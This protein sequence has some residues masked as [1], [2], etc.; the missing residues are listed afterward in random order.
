MLR[1]GFEPGAK[2]ESTELWRPPAKGR[3]LKYT[4]L[5]PLK[6]L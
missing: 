2:D 3:E 5:L 4:F 1:L 6:S